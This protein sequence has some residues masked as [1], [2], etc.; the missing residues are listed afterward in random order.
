MPQV[1]VRFTECRQNSQEAGTDD[2]HMVSRVFFN[3]E[4]DGTQRGDYYVDLKQTVGSTMVEGLIQV[5]WPTAY[6]GPWN[7]ETFANAVREYF[8]QCVGPTASVVQI[9]SGAIAMHE[10]RF[11]VTKTTKFTAPDVAAASW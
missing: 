1:V 3:I 9:G 7:Q 4:V 10:T 11:V 5:P 2:E 8:G 6:K